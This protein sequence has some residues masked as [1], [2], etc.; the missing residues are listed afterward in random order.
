MADLTNYE[1]AQVALAAVD[2]NLLNPTAASLDTVQAVATVAV[3]RS[4]LALVDEL[5]QQPQG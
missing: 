5:K 4:V 2:Q 1:A 3:A